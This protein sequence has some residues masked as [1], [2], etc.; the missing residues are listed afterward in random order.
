MHFSK[1]PRTAKAGTTRAGQ[2]RFLGAARAAQRARDHP[3]AGVC[4]GL[5]YVA[6]R[7]RP[8]THVTSSLRFRSPSRSPALS[9]AVAFDGNPPGGA[10]SGL[11]VV[12]LETVWKTVS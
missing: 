3:R 1:E 7:L 9:Q 8:S 4:G 6:A 11:G 5:P 12:S 2:L 10:K